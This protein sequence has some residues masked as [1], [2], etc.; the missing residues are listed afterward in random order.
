MGSEMCIRDSGQPLR[1]PA[2][3]G[4][5]IYIFFV[6]VCVCRWWCGTKWDPFYQQP[7]PA[8]RFRVACASVRGELYMPFRNVRKRTDPGPT[9]T[10]Q[11]TLMEWV[12]ATRRTHTNAQ[13][14]HGGAP[15][16]QNTQL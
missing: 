16:G 6:C 1:V 8:C 3:E 4:G 2:C 7:V 11:D 5:S 10:G 15:L 9:R 13:T 12:V 14:R